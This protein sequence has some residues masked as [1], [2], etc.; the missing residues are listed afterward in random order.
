MVNY[1]DLGRKLRRYRESKGWNQNQMAQELGISA[2]FEGHLERGSRKAS[3]E[4]LVDI[5]N[6]TGLST[7]FLLSASLD[8]YALDPNCGLNANQRN[9]LREILDNLQGQLLYWNRDDDEEDEAPQD[10]I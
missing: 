5:A 1:E 3:L 2:S 10:N 6:V 4:T 8:R 9:V 7:D